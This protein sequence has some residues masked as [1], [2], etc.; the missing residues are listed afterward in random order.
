MSM[1]A[2]G[3]P[4]LCLVSEAGRSSLRAKQL[5]APEAFESALVKL[6]VVNNVL[7]HKV[8]K[9]LALLRE[10]QMLAKQVGEVMFVKTC[11]TNVNVFLTGIDMYFDK[12]YRHMDP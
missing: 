10:T 6:G 3:L 9:G 2:H 7:A 1:R 12:F 11:E 8:G 4:L 5:L